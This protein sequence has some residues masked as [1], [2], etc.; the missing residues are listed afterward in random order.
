M[1]LQGDKIEEQVQ[2]AKDNLATD[3]A[4]FLSSWLSTLRAFPLGNGSSV[5]SL[6]EDYARLA[7]RPT[8]LGC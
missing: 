1:S 8:P 6:E 3:E 7:G 2:L 5:G 4:G